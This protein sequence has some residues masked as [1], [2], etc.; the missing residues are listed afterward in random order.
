MDIVSAATLVKPAR[1]NH[2]AGSRRV[3]GSATCEGV[4]CRKVCRR[5][6]GALSAGIMM[7]S[8]PGTRR[9]RSMSSAGRLGC[10]WQATRRRQPGFRV[11]HRCGAVAP[12][13]RAWLRG[14]LPLR[15]ATNGAGVGR[16]RLHI[17]IRSNIT[18]LSARA[19]EP[20]LR[21]LAA[22]QHPVRTTGAAP[23]QYLCPRP[24]ALRMLGTP[25]QI[26]FG[27]LGATVRAVS[28][29]WHRKRC[30]A[31]A[32]SPRGSGGA[33]ASE[34]AQLYF[35]SQAATSQKTGEV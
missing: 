7:P 16:L 24:H 12:G 27:N 9:V 17:Y 18:Q 26:V 3:D 30:M 1:R 32:A 25:T 6:T 14:L 35:I 15:A 11:P 19:R 10:D 33:Y 31:G 28:P 21:G 34:L 4:W 2:A 22:A 23:R 13:R 29:C 5:N 20:A 8:T